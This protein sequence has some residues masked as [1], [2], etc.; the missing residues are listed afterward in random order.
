MSQ[1]RRHIADTVLH[2]SR[3]VCKVIPDLVI[4]VYFYHVQKRLEW[5]ASVIPNAR[6]VTWR[7]VN[8]I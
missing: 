4:S 2:A 7:F 8:T 1:D 5:N 6:T 3:I